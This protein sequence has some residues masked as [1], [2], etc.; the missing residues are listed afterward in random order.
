MDTTIDSVSVQIESNSSKAASSIDILVASIMK[1]KSATNNGIEGLSSLDKT[2]TNLR[3]NLSGIS[4]STSNI[5]K[6][7][8]SLTN[9]KNS[10]TTM[11]G[12]F[13]GNIKLPSNDTG[14]KQIN[15]DTSKYGDLVREQIKNGQTQSKVYEKVSNGIKTVTIVTGKAITQTQSM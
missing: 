9:L 14:L 3:S 15:V 7:S 2:I 13:T 4:S 12:K 6:V 1:I 11:T 8:K 10:A 5:D